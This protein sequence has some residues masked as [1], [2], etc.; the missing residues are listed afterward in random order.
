MNCEISNFVVGMK[1]VNKSKV[2][3]INCKI[4]NNHKVDNS[5]FFD[6][7]KSSQIHSITT[8]FRKCCH[9]N[10]ISVSSRSFMNFSQCSFSKFRYKLMAFSKDSK[11]IIHNCT[12]SNSNNYFYLIYFNQS[13]CFCSDCSFHSIN[14]CSIY[15]DNES[16]LLLEQSTL[17]KCSS[18]PVL[19]YN[20]SSGEIFNSKFINSQLDGISILERSKVKI[21][22]TY[23]KNCSSGIV[24]ST[25]SESEV[26]GC[27]FRHIREESI[28]CYDSG[29]I[30][31]VNCS[32][33]DPGKE[34][35]FSEKEGFIQVSDSKMKQWDDSI[36]ISKIASHENYRFQ[37]AQLSGEDL[38]SHSIVLV[39]EVLFG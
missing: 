39:M 29:I 16:Q 36:P 26:I 31:L 10:A 20:N 34:F 4:E 13:Q 38:L 11:G 21:Q 1:V 12:F 32:I 8:S 3:M 5:K 27:T 28:Y 19:L 37:I 30:K 17:D 25:N 2:S 14:Y 18:T 6:I 24:S 23:F 7:S 35:F 33:T 15:I 22:D 9:I